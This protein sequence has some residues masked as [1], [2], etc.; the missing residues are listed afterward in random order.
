[1]RD[2]IA[3]SGAPL[4]PYPDKVFVGSSTIVCGDQQKCVSGWDADA[5]MMIATRDARSP[6][7]SLADRFRLER[8]LKA[9]VTA[10]VGLAPAAQYTCTICF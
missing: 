3:L 5:T 4:N 8:G 7:G 1:M 6:V 10:L 9:G 2:G